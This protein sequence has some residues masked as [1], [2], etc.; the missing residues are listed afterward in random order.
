MQQGRTDGGGDGGGP[1]R[2]GRRGGGLS[3]TIN[4]G[5]G[6]HSE[7]R[8]EGP[9]LWHTQPVNTVVCGECH[10]DVVGQGGSLKSGRG[11]QQWWCMQQASAVCVLGQTPGQTG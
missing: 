2:G 6:V 5:E 9:E 10:G 3:F 4:V 11:P 8:F 7:G 1:A